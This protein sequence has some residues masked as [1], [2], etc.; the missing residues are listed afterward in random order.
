M[1]TLERK[2]LVR[3]GYHDR[4][5]CPTSAYIELQEQTLG[6]KILDPSSE[7]EIPCQLDIIGNGK[8]RLSWIV[9]IP[10][11]QERE[12]KLILY[13]QGE[14]S[15]SVGLKERNGEIDFI[16]RGN[17]F[18]TYHFSQDL[19]RPFLHPVIGPYGKPVTRGFPMIPDDPKE[20]KD[21]PHHRSI[22]VAHGDVNG[23]DNWSEEKGHGRTVHRGFEAKRSGPILSELIALSDWVSNDGKTLLVERRAM[24][25]YNTSE[26]CRILDIDVELS[27]ILEEVTF[28]DTKEGGMIS[29]RVAS[30]MD[31]ERGGKIENSYGGINEAETW[32]KRAHWCDYSGQVEGDRVGIAIFDHISNFRHPTYWHVR[33]YGL[34]TANPFG[35]SYFTNDPY[36][37]GTYVLHNRSRFVFKYRILIHK[38][39]AKEGRVAE[40]YLDYIYPPS[41]SIS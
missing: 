5:D 39:D 4:I 13:K 17:L 21:H 20:V 2:L 1:A 30:S 24:K 14:T 9:N 29:V 37:K 34:M 11:G 19:A 3:A 38:G 22:W 7:K 41:V 8:A 15:A 32:G 33:D 12:Y 27:P 40:R 18:T 31:V 35:I 25:V 6:A 26:A 16:I 10:K 23:V 28:G 36:N